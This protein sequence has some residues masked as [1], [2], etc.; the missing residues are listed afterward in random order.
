MPPSPGA[1]LRYQPRPASNQLK[2]IVEDS[3]E[4]LF[5]ERLPEFYETLAYHYKQGQSYLKAVDYLMKA[6]EKCLERYTV[7]ESHQY[8][9]EAFDILS[10]KLIGLRT[11]TPP[12]QSFIQW[13]CILFSCRLWRIRGLAETS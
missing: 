11:K 3:M 4:E 13:S 10:N 2:E 5:R 1:A 8:Y 6:G 7:E 9:K 12:H